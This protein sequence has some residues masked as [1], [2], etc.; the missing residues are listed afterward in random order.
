[1][2]LFFSILASILLFKVKNIYIFDNTITN[3]FNDYFSVMKKI[4]DD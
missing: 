1:M 3:C 4:G 2:G